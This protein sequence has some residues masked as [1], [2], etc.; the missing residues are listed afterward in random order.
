MDYY[1]GLEP[2][3]TRSI[4][5]TGALLTYKKS[6]EV[7]SAFASSLPH[8]LDVT[9]TPE[10]T[11]MPSG[12]GY[13]CEVHLPEASPVSRAVGKVANSKQVAK[14]SAAYAVCIQLIDQG[15]LDDRLRS[16]FNELL[17]AM[18]NARLALSSKKQA[19]YTM[20]IK[21]DIWDHRGVP[22]RLF[23]TIFQLSNPDALGRSS[24]PLAILTREPLPNV[25]T[26]PLFFGNQRTSKV[27][28]I[29]IAPAIYLTPSEV[30]GLN[31]FAL[32]I[33]RDVF[34]KEYES[35]PEKMPYFLAPILR[36]HQFDFGKSE[37]S[38]REL[39]DW[40][41][42]DSVQAVT[43]GIEWEGQPDHVFKNKFVTDPHDGSRKFYTADLRRDLKPTDPQLPSAPK[44]Q[45][46]NKAREASRDIWNY[47][48]SLWSNSRSKI[49]VRQ[50]LPVIEAEF[51]PLRRNLLDE[52][53][54]VDDTNLKC[55]IVLQTMKLSA[56]SFVSC[57]GIS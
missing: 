53:E 6:L 18:R 31:E 30:H 36:A 15:F 7:L 56:V 46:C 35:A 34:S 26:S 32:R 28:Y 3:P 51:V 8:P 19:E 1:L 39:I 16:T 4:A 11:V 54:R 40:A 9:Y 48:V 52:F 55:Y 10:Y 57:A 5:S 47:S 2:T 14:C 24:R 43:D 20:R 25:A 29:P 27:R 45:Q 21:P 49:P 42:I 12:S 38:P 44:S 50:D 33:F 23:L 13:I 22:A 17:P 37:I 41:C